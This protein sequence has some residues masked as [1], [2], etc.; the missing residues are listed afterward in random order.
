MKQKILIALLSA[1]LI[2]VAI[3]SFR[4]REPFAS[5]YSGDI[6]MRADSTVP[7]GFLACNGQA[8]SRTGYALLFSVI[9]TRYG[10]GDGSTTFN[11]PDTRDRFPMSA[12]A[13][14]GRAPIGSTGG[15]MDHDHG[16][17]ITSGTPSATVAATNLTGSA[18]STTHT[19][20]VT[21]TAQNP[22]YITLYFII[23]T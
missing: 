15:V 3:I 7:V 13:S 12:A 19:H 11:V 4:P 5:Y 18:A 20:S 9:G 8:V 23:K 14:G 6:A 22:A 17:P 16:S 2:V 21:L 1:A 10:A